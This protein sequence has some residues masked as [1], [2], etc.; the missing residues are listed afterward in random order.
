VKLKLGVV[1]SEIL[2]SFLAGIA[3]LYSEYEQHRAI[4]LVQVS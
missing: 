1:S 4:H 3:I 2:P